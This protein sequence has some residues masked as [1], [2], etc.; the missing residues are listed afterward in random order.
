MFFSIVKMVLYESIKTR[1]MLTYSTQLSWYMFWI[2]PQF[3]FA[4]L[5]QYHS[6]DQGSEMWA[7][8]VYLKQTWNWV[9]CYYKILIYIIK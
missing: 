9:I 3:G 8:P 4:A 2:F 7:M 6:I 5:C 1:Y